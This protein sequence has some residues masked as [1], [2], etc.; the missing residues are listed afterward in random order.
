[1]LKCLAKYPTDFYEISPA[2]ERSL[3]IVE[4]ELHYTMPYCVSKFHQHRGFNRHQQ[5]RS[6]KV[7]LTTI[8]PHIFFFS[9]AVFVFP[10]FFAFPTILNSTNQNFITKKPKQK[11]ETWLVPIYGN[12]CLQNF[13]CQ[14]KRQGKGTLRCFKTKDSRHS[15]IK[16]TYIIYIIHL[17][18]SSKFEFVNSGRVAQKNETKA[19]IT[20]LISTDKI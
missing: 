4:F 1:M 13:P 6:K 9:K 19:T 8:S 5:T 15:K 2:E 17:Y 10:S 18:Q 3:I 7:K 20:H 12:E 14:M 11:I 16:Y